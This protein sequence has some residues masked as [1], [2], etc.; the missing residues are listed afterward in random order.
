MNMYTSW[1][2]FV[3]ID[4]NFSQSV[5]FVDNHAND[6][7]ITC[8]RWIHRPGYIPAHPCK[9]IVGGK[10]DH[11]DISHAFDV[12]QEGAFVLPSNEKMAIGRPP[13]SLVH[14]SHPVAVSDG[15]TVNASAAINLDVKC[16]KLYWKSR[17]FLPEKNVCLCSRVWVLVGEAWWGKDSC[18]KGLVREAILGSTFTS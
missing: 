12:R 5:P 9:V 17:S 18:G 13:A 14:Q 2:S 1:N 11:D 6:G 15:H 7:L 8:N 10:G 16:S 3:G 4:I